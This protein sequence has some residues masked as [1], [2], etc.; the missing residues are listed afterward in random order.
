MRIVV[1][2]D[3][4]LLREGLQLLLT[5]AGHEVVGSVADGPS[6]T[7]TVLELRPELGI[8]DVRMPPSH[9]DEGLRAAV[10][11]RR[12][13]PEARLMVLSQYVEVSYADDLLATGDGGV[14]YLLKD[15]VS[16]LDDFLGAVQAVA[17][18]GTVLDPMVVR[19]LMGR[20]R[21]PLADLTPREREVLSLMAEGKSNAAIAAALSVSLAGVEKHTQRIFA[22]L[23]LPPDDDTAHRR[24]A[25]VLRFLG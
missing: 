25:A 12:A 14:G 16:D 19:Q 6:F 5:E 17:A 1:A 20:N 21:D 24:V 13:W 23:G 10:D 18:G 8:V 22:K 7:A 15:R 2:D 11:V 3:S 4:L 9:T